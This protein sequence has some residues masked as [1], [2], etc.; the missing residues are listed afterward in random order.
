[1]REITKPNGEVYCWVGVDG[2]LLKIKM[3]QGTGKGMT[4]QL[5][6]KVIP[7]LRQLLTEA[8]FLKII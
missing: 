1:M 2:G 6:E 8:E 7:Q 5:D 3:N 4:V